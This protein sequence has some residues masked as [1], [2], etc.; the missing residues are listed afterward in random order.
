[1]KIDSLKL[2]KLNTRDS[3]HL[4]VESDKVTIISQF[5]TWCAPCLREMKGLVALKQN[6]NDLEVF[7]IS[8]EDDGVLL[9]FVKKFPE[10]ENYIYK[11]ADKILD[12]S[13]IPKAY[14]Y[15]N[16]QFLYYHGESANW[17]NKSNIQ[18]LNQ[19]LHEN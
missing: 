9:K 11:D 14:L 7:F 8:K 13:R 5:A 18:F 6:M 10:F 4:N 1:M 17:N 3:I 15:I 12:Y 19:I 16:G 2:V